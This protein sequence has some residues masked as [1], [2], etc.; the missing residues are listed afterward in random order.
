M[1]DPSDLPTPGDASPPERLPTHRPVLLHEAIEHLDPQPGEI[2]VDATAGL[3][4]H[5]KAI[6]ER[7]GPGG[8]LLLLD[9]DEPNLHHAKS[10]VGPQ[11]RTLLIHSNFE[12]L[13]NVLQNAQIPQIDILLADLGVSSPQL[14]QAERGFSFRRDGPLDMRMNASEGPSAADLVAQLSERELAWIFWEYGEERFSRQVARRIAES[15]RTEAIRTTFQLADL[16]RQVVP[17]ERRHQGTGIDPATR[18]FQGLRIAVNDELG[19]LE[20]LLKSL[21]KLVRPGGRVA[22]ISFHSLED[23]RVKQAFGD[24]DVWHRITKKPVTASDEEARQ[25]PRSRSAKLRVVRRA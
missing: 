16:V 9:R 23:R 1:S 13:E 8:Q 17:R 18:V 24:R 3:G 11:T 19:S 10:A 15:R 25:N 20:R 12:W 2:A 22:V 21:P 5:A 14:D 4:G 6:A 7:I